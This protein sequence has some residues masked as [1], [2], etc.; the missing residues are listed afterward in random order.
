M[1]RCIFTS[2][3]IFHHLTQRSLDNGDIW[4]WREKAHLKH[5]VGFSN[6]PMSL[7]VAYV[8]S[9]VCVC[10]CVCVYVCACV[11]KPHMCLSV[12]MAE[13]NRK[14][15]FCAHEDTEKHPQP[16]LCSGS[17]W[18]RLLSWAQRFLGETRMEV[19]HLAVIQRKCAK[20]YQNW[21]SRLQLCSMNEGGSEFPS[22]PWVE[23]SKNIAFSVSAISMAGCPKIPL[24]QLT[25]LK[26]IRCLS[27][28]IISRIKSFFFEGQKWL[29]SE[30][31][32][33]FYLRSWE[34]LSCFSYV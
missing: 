19:E 10:V 17:T 32:I 22:N 27:E 23:F 29:Y 21:I 7:T 1:R 5:V 33:H 13:L 16:P 11:C 20:C 31:D 15:I 6:D 8:S 24:H 12:E 34:N 25:K 26:N 18:S 30:K 28:K 2:N 9:C 4:D 3:L 14:I